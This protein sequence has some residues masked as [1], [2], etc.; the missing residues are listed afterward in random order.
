MLFSVRRS[1]ELLRRTWGQ[2]AFL[3]LVYIILVTMCYIFVSSIVRDLLTRSA[4]D[5]LT[6]MEARVASDILESET[7]LRSASLGIQRM[8]ASGSRAGEVLEYMK[9]FSQSV[10]DDKRRISGESGL[11]G[12]FNV[13]RGRFLDGSGREAP[14]NF[15]CNDKLWYKAAVAADGAIATTEPYFD[16]ESR[17][18]VISYSQH[19]M[20]GNGKSLA[21]IGLNMPL[22]NLK[23]YFSG[24]RLAEGGYGIMA[25][26][27]LKIIVGPVDTTIGQHLSV[28]MSPDIVRIIDLLGSGEHLTDY[29]TRNYRQ[30][31]E[32][33]S[34]HSRQIMNGWHIGIL[35][36]INKY[37]KDLFEKA[38]T[39]IIIGSLLNLFLSLIVLHIAAAKLLAD[40]KDKR[41]SS[42]LANMSHEIRTPMNAIIGFAELAMREDIPPAAYE[43]IFTIKQAGANLLSIINDILDISKIESG[44]LEIVNGDYLFSSLVNDVVSIIKMRAT[45]ARLRFVVNVDS[46]IPN[47]LIGD[48]VRMRQILLNLL[49]NAVKYTDKG[50]LSLTVT[51][52]TAAEDTVILRVDVVDSGKGIP[53]EDIDKLFKDF[54]RIDKTRNKGI[55]GTGLGL[56]ITKNILNA[57]GGEIT[58]RSEYGK[59]ST[60]T[61]RVPQKFRDP[62]RH[63]LVDDCN[64]KDVLIYERREIYATSV[65]R[66]IENLGVNCE[67]VAGETELD[68]KV[69]EKKHTFIF[70]APAL[71]ERTKK[72]LRKHRSDSKV[73]LLTEFGDAIAD[74]NATILSMPVYSITVSNVLNGVS[75]DTD[76]GQSR[77]D[78]IARFIAPEAN[79]MLVDD[80]GTNLR[81]AEGLLAPY[82]MR[83]T[84]CK[85][86]VE[87]VEAA[88]TGNFDIIFMDHMMP[89]MDGIEA[90]K[91]IR[92]LGGEYYKKLPIVALT[93]N[94]VTGMKEMFL[95]EGLNDFISKPIDITK[96][97][98]VLDRWIPKAKRKSTADVSVKPDS[99][100]AD[101][102][103][104][105]KISIDGVDTQKGLAMSGGNGAYYVRTLTMFYEDGFGK[106]E[107]MKKCL[108][109]GD[110]QLYA[111]HVHGLKSASASIGASDLSTSA[112]ELEIAG[113]ENNKTFIGEHNAKFVMDLEALLRNIGRIL[114]EI[115][116]SKGISQDKLSA[117]QIEPELVRLRDALDHFDSEVIDQATTALQEFEHSIEYGNEVKAILQDVLIGEYDNALSSIEKLLEVFKDKKRA[118]IRNELDALDPRR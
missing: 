29:R 14:P 112:W 73:V 42:F 28:L 37:Y 80:T 81:V 93:A 23:K 15:S 60:F 83:L 9:D 21:V 100:G 65:V 56:A 35:T 33:I 97:N 2:L 44:K 113:K 67:L 66:T 99:G 111:T 79:V 85:S 103:E 48:E 92:S 107:E 10:L 61:M 47:A 117:E 64:S 11:Y 95:S 18:W 54:V 106:I 46:N 57:M 105:E 39:L 8:V 49:S 6:N 90:T 71:Y 20:D 31:G 41:K 116:A 76:Y 78:G 62:K 89:G 16:E 87:A 45:Y 30:N 53:K 50:F 114:D 98:S 22:V 55:E 82:K 4:E 88:R 3:W 51:Q 63:A 17:E 118:A 40:E 36:P 69:A 24:I 101:G 115:E 19:V 59:G 110:L 34:V 86:G 12:V 52:E 104:I 96:L 13:Y 72:I 109:M 70:T 94:A 84:L 91:R 108:D 75:G 26:S 58:V 68:E 1:L 77:G 32:L 25:D 38:F 74:R 7:A 5:M 43:H 102:V 27:A